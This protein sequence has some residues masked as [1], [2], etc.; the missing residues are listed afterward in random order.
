M[1]SIRAMRVV[2]FSV[3]SAILL[4]S[5]QPAHAKTL[6]ESMDGTGDSI[7]VAFDADDST[8][9]YS[10]QVGND[11]A[12]GVDHGTNLC[13]AGPNGGFSHAERLECAKG[14]PITV[15]NDAVSGASMVGDF[16]NQ[17]TSART[18]LSAAPALHYVTVFMGHN[19][20]CTETVSKSGNACSG[21]QDPENYC[22]STN[23][24]FERELRKG[25][26]QLIQIPDTRIAVLA[27]VRVSA[28][29]NLGTKNA[30]GA[31]AIFGSCYNLWAS[32]PVP[33]CKS[34]TTDCSAERQ[35]DMYNTLVGY[36]AILQRVTRE[37]GRIR[38][39]RASTTAAV[40]AKNV[41]LRFGK[42]S[43]YG[44]FT[45]QDLSCCD[46]F[47]PS[48][49]GQARLALGAWVGFKCSKA[50][51]C[52]GR[53]SDKLAEAQCIV[54]DTRRFYHGGFWPRSLRKLAP[55]L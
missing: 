7:S 38:T 10:P 20:A 30:C 47:H 8:C 34:L 46:C 54:Q 11:W 37:Y 16:A 23:A 25:L 50:T 53:S 28:L 52:C 12:G 35:L 18:N 33:I 36:N 21:D 2:A 32:G 44:A 51:P 4:L 9:T 3:L 42:G 41:R 40:K 43:F 27:T 19:D 26:D 24:A 15:F 22:R 31:G 39:G 6:A 29:C 17:A 48:L 13:S 14:A 55:G 1:F 5:R 49:F 45:E